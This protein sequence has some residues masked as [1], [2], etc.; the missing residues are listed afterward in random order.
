M[1]KKILEGSGISAREN[2]GGLL[3]VWVRGHREFL[4]ISFFVLFSL[5]LKLTFSFFVYGTNDTA[6]WLRFSTTLDEIGSFNI[7]P[8]TTT[9]NHPPLVSQLLGIVSW[10]SAG[11]GLNFPFVFRLMPI[12]ADSASIFV[13]WRLLVMYGVKNRVAIGS[14]CALNPIN[15][16][17]SG[18][19][20]NTDPIFIF[21]VLLMLYCLEKNQVL[22]GGIAFGLSIGVKV[23]PLIL[24]PIALLSP[25][26]YKKENSFPGVIRGGISGYFRTLS[27]G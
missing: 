3:F 14:L 19:H 9:Y 1:G 10:F 2:G 4:V 26:R 5:F 27:L 20:S 21:L 15:F 24:V 22:F 7:Y 16:L 18:F 11:T 25:P 8:L 23:V 17:V 13:I 12:V 6:A